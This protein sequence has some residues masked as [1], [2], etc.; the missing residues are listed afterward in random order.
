MI[1]GSNA[2][3]ARY[4]G[5]YRVLF[6]FFLLYNL[7]GVAY[8][9]K[10]TGQVKEASGEILGFSTILV[11]GT[12]VGTSANSEG[13]YS[14][15]LPEGEYT[16]SCRFMG[17][18]TVSKTVTLVGQEQRLDFTMQP[19]SFEVA[20]VVV[21][22]DAE[23]PAYA[24]MREVIARR[25]E[26]ADRVQTLET[27]VYLKAL[28]HTR[29]M[30]E[31]ILGISLSDADFEASRKEMNLDTA[32]RGILYALEEVS[33]YTFQQPGHSRNYVLSVRESGDPQG[34]GFAS[35]P[36][37]TNIYDNNINLLGV[38]ERGFISPAS[39][40]AFLYYA[41]ELLGSFREGDRLIHKIGVTPRRKFEPAF[42]GT[43]YVVEGEWLFQSLDLLLTR[44][45]Q[46]NILDTL[47]LEQY[48][49]PIEGGIWSIQSQRIYLTL[50]IFGFDLAGD[51]VTVYQNQ[52]INQPLP[53]E[54]FDSKVLAS[55][56]SLAQD[57]DSA[58]WNAIRPIPLKQEE[59]RNFQFKDSIYHSQDEKKDSLEQLPRF[60]LGIADFLLG[61]PQVKVGKNTWS[62]RPL[63]GAVQYNNVEGLSTTLDLLWRHDFNEESNFSLQWLNRYGW[64]NKQGHSLLKA[65]FERKDPT[66]KTRYWRVGLSGGSY[67]YQINRMN[68]I[69]PFLNE[70]YTL[71]GGRN[72]MK[73]F[74]NR[75]IR[76]QV[77]RD[78]GNGFYAQLQ[79][80]YNHHLALHNTSLYTFSA[81]TR[82][83]LTPNQPAGLPMWT[84]HY[85]AIGE[86]VLRYQP[87]VHYIQY[88]KFKSPV[89]SRAPV[90]ELAYAK[91]VPGLGRAE[92]DFDKWELTVD[93]QFRLRLL[94]NLNYRL[95]AGGFLNDKMVNLPDWN[96]LNGNQTFLSGLFMQS[97]QLAPYYRFSNHAEAYFKGHTEWHL[98]GLFTNKIPGFRRLEWHLVAGSNA[99]FINQRDYYAEI[100]VGL[101]NIGWKFFRPGRVDLIAGYVS[102]VRTPVLG[103]RL[104]LG[105]ALNSLFGTQ[106]NREL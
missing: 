39:S 92:A 2:V 101:E 50:N 22:S 23:D 9:V 40:N 49:R 11:E 18:R 57:R 12:T 90:F 96:H 82:S 62:M 79:L 69:S 44:Q 76:L 70:A 104:S 35:M 73:L 91:A 103:L 61:R 43:V 45:S 77:E 80:S 37:I 1:I 78:W 46:M 47:R 87:G 8:G 25:K 34:L 81:T 85:A 100:F 58:Y 67:L 17:Y 59:V 75:H 13:W 42:S 65:A 24:I 26:H 14:V 95:S 29:A 71:L 20:E 86:L 53:E 102:G 88:P 16:I 3:Y 60:S 36:P 6:F 97:F 93:H 15:D 31:K 5:M 99:L 84:S 54:V 30:P 33:H 52:K 83:K 38:N 94:G 32:G 89:R 10:L 4:A 63:V 98:G 21:R 106:N 56:D 64:S 48:Y 7:P 74:A 66:W 27:E 28:L 19:E 72:Y 105:G 51:M 41:Y 68:P 55:Y